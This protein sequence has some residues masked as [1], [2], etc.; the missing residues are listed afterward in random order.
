VLLVYQNEH[1]P[2][3]RRPDVIYSAAPKLG[4]FWDG[5]VVGEI[6]KRT[7]RDYVKWRTSQPQA[8]YKDPKTAPRVGEQTARRELEVLQSAINYAVG[9]RLLKYAVPVHL[10]QK[11]EPRERWLTRDEVAKLLW[12]AWRADQGRSRQICADSSS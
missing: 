3:T 7:C 2:T 5:K 4:E 6:T 10:P 9:E 1:G 8:R 12:A 11:A